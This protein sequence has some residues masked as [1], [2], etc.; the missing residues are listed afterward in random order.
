ML[1][2]TQKLMHVQGAKILILKSTLHLHNIVHVFIGL[3]FAK[4]LR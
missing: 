4:L 1:I 2:Q 3:L